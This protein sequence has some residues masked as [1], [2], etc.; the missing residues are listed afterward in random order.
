[1]VIGDWAA[2]RLENE[3]SLLVK[4]NATIGTRVAE[5]SVMD[6]LLTGLPTL[7]YA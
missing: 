4:E 3:Y 5:R 2:R 1:M 6:G 7:P